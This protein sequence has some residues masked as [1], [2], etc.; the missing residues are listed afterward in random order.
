MALFGNI[1]GGLFGQQKVPKFNQLSPDELLK[2]SLSSIPQIAAGQKEQAVGQA[3]AQRAAEDIFDPNQARLRETTS[4]R[5]LSDLNLGG[6]LPADVQRLVTDRALGSG[7][8]SGLGLSKAGRS[9]VAR[10]LGLTGLDLINDR[11]SRAASFT[12][13]APTLSQIYN[14]S[15]IG[16]DPGDVAGQIVASNNAQNAFN[17][18]KSG[19][20]SRNLSNLIQTPIKLASTFFNPL[21]SV[22]GPAQGVGG[23]LSFSNILSGLF[24]P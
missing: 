20:D 3:T 22:G 11:L 12:R 19:V 7:I 13:S 17:Q 6:E 10:D 1:L 16:I 4:S 8:A 9:V 5:I 18:F 21:G 24:K 2:Q 23:G 15:D 14:P